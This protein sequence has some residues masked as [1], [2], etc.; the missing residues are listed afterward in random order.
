VDKLFQL[1]DALPY[2]LSGNLRIMRRTLEVSLRDIIQRT[3][4]NLLVRNLNASKYNFNLAQVIVVIR[5]PMPPL[6]PGT[7]QTPL[8][9]LC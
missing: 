1:E 9:L 6:P 7:V 3:L 8:V 4:L 5:I 2:R